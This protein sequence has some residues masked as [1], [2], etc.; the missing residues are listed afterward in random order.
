MRVFIPAP[1]VLRLAAGE[2]QAQIARG[3]KW[4]GCRGLTR[5]GPCVN[6]RPTKSVRAGLTAAV[7]Q[8]IEPATPLPR[9]LVRVATGIEPRATSQYRLSGTNGCDMTCGMARPYL[10]V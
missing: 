4:P 10:S 2:D 5:L 8:T 1:L 7:A 6:R 9:S 3:V